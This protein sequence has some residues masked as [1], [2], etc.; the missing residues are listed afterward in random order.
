MLP[1]VYSELLH[2]RYMEMVLDYAEYLGMDPEEDGDFLWIAESALRA[3]V[4]QHPASPTASSCHST[5]LPSTQ[6]GQHQASHA[7]SWSRIRCGCVTIT[8]RAVCESTGEGGGGGCRGA[9][10]HR[11]RRCRSLRAGRR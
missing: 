7:P 1:Y 2:L 11:G 6:S 4:R 8:R 9:N 10:L 3:P 5:R